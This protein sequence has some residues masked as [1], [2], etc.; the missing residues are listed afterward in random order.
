MPK[1]PKPDRN[2]P[3][4]DAP[5]P[6]E[7]SID[8]D[9]TA[10]LIDD[11]SHERD[12]LSEENNRLLLAA[13][14]LQN[15]VRTLRETGPKDVAEARRQVLAS[16]ARDVV[17][18]VDTFELALNH[19]PA[20]VPAASIMQ[21]V[22]AIREGLLKALA[23]HGIHPFAPAPNDPFE[24]GRHEAV[25]VMSAEGVEPGR[26]VATFQVGYALHDRVLRPAKVAV[27]PQT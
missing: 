26:V 27:A 8:P 25:T 11:L 1:E 9:E 7:Y 12:R 2:T 24:P 21:G 6:G 10:A 4:D 18:A 19:D 13:A 20:T 14:E 16:V 22:V 23:H 5:P 3:P 15:Q 17:Q